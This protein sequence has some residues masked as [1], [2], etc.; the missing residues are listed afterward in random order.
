M[1]N[2]TIL[3][4]GLVF[5]FFASV[6]AAEDRISRGLRLAREAAVAAELSAM[7][8]PAEVTI[9]RI[10]DSVGNTLEVE[11]TPP[12]GKSVD[13]RVVA[14]IAVGD[15]SD[16]ADAEPL[17]LSGY[18]IRVDLVS[19]ATSCDLESIEK[20]KPIKLKGDGVLLIY[21]DTGV[22][23][24]AAGFPTKGDVNVIMLKGKDELAFCDGSVRK[25]QTLDYGTCILHDCRSGTRLWG[26]VVND[27]ETKE[28]TYVAVFQATYTTP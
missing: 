23:H 17:D 27:S 10:R 19:A 25:G 24:S 22:T 1:E 16:E 14:W 11:V 26:A 15:E 18:R 6:V 13:P 12:L 3:F 2:R 9:A 7:T 20:T 8:R 28:A 4:R 5:L 21:T